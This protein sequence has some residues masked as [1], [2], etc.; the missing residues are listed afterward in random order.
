MHRISQPL[1][2]FSAALALLAPWQS[3]QSALSNPFAARLMRTMEYID[4]PDVLVAIAAQNTRPWE[5]YDSGE[6]SLGRATPLEPRWNQ[7]ISLNPSGPI[8]S[9]LNAIH[10]VFMETSSG[11]FRETPIDD[12]G[13][14]IDRGVGGPGG[15]DRL[16][17]SQARALQ[18]NLLL[19]AEVKPDPYNKTTPGQTML[20]R[21]RYPSAATYKKF[22]QFLS[23]Q[24]LQDLGT[25][26]LA[27]KLA[28]DINR[29]ESVGPEFR[30][31]NKRILAELLE[32]FYD[33][34]ASPVDNYQSMITVHPFDDYNGRSLRA[35]YREQAGRP[36]F[37]MNFYCDLYCG[38]TEF[39]N[40]VAR[41]DREYDQIEAGLEREE[42]ANPGYPRFYDVPEF[43]MVA[44]GAQAEPSDPGRY[45][46]AS[47]AW[48]LRVENSQR[49]D[50]KLFDEV[51]R[52]F[53]AYLST[54]GF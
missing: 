21:Y 44:S 43:W 36:L 29:P 18:A 13:G 6:R 39:E 2:A 4:Y 48:F 17:L 10:N 23:A 46:G 54:L 26:E 11:D 32:A 53:R 25:A 8:E 27:G 1:F 42:N 35:W 37:L 38:R 9:Q 12:A 30:A 40:E 49:I 41:G 50:H 24:L 15:F 16:T 33:P 45:V 28:Y 31:L 52:D 22:Q 7:A 5:R 20:A 3:A 47:K 51:L 19:V 34:S 14:D